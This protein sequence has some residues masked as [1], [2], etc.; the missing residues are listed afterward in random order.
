MKKTV[1]VELPTN[2]GLKQPAPGHEPGVRK[3]PEWLRRNGFHELINPVHIHTLIPPPYSMHLDK[4]SNVRNADAIASFAVEQAALIKQLLP[5]HFIIAIGGDCSVLIGTALALKQPGNYGLFYLDGHHDFMLPSLSSTHG[6][7]GMDLAIVT[8]YGH[9]KL[10]NI[11]LAKPYLQEKNIWCVGNREFDENY[12]RPVKETAIHY[13]D[14]PTL[15]SI[16]IQSCVNEFLYWIEQQNLDGFWI[17]LD[18]DV[19][20]DE[21]MPA[22]DSRE[23]GGLSYDELKAILKPLLD[24]KKAKGIEITILDPELDVEGTYTAHLIV[25]L[26]EALAGKAGRR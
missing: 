7:A 5:D 25:N 18:V 14:L 2:L 1:I 10:T 11:E 4:E 22:V 13:Y 15:R 8:G 21:L 20:D 24:H 17:H 9:D 6:A 16:G 23:P 19:L 3:L 26:I 12:V